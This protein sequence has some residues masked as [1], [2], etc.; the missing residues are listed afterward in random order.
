MKKIYNIM[1]FMLASVLVFSSCVDEYQDANPEPQLDGPAGFV[2]SVTGATAAEYR[3]G[4]EFTFTL[5]GETVTFTIDMVDVPGLIDS[6]GLGLTNIIRPNNFG[7]LTADLGAAEGSTSGEVTI[8]Y[9]ASTEGDSTVTNAYT[10]NLIVE[11]YD[12]QDP[13][14]VQSYAISPIRVINTDCLSSTSLVGTYNTVSS[15]FD[16]EAGAA[17]ENL[18]SEVVVDMRNNADH[19]GRYVFSDRSFGLYA[20]QGFNPTAGLVTACENE[21]VDTSGAFAGNFTGTVDPATGIITI[22]WENTFGDTGTT[23]MTPQ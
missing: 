6:V 10:E 22:T 18:V 5:P 20:A 17:Y 9:V 3:N 14:K 19:P 1:M 21:I 23:V 7:T 12:R 16:S 15:G 13:P 2:S 8:T 4:N 11:V